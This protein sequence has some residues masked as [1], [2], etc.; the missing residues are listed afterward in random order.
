MKKILTFAL[1]SIAA[2]IFAVAG[3][4]FGGT[5]LSQP[6]LYIGALF[7]GSL[8]VILAGLITRKVGWIKPSEFRAATIGGVL[9]FLMAAALAVY[10]SQTF[11]NPVVPVLSVSLVGIGFLLDAK[12]GNKKL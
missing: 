11:N 3:S 2:G 7:L 8:G 6:G 5:L 4:I 12:Q 9:G 1:V 10:G